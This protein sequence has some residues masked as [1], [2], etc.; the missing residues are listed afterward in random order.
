MTQYQ[1]RK[2]QQIQTP[3]QLADLDGRRRSGYLV[4]V[5]ATK[6]PKRRFEIGDRFEYDGSTWTLV[7]MYRLENEPGVWH[8][9][10]EEVRSGPDPVGA[11]LVSLGAGETT[12][13][14]MYEAFRS[15]GD[16][17]GFF[18]DICMNG[19]QIDRTTP[20]LLKLRKLSRK[21][22]TEGFP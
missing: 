12:P 17:R 6:P 13:R 22:A 15:A 16:A 2:Y 20:E 4:R 1:P 10:L 18:A 3:S 19:H 7:Y 11:A 14:V 9:V 5:R 21:E 8:H